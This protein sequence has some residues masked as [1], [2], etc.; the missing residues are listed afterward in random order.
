MKAKKL[1][2]MMTV[3]MFAFFFV[4][5]QAFAAGQEKETGAVKSQT[6]E[7]GTQKG[8]SGGAGMAAVCSRASEIIGRTVKNDKGEEL[9][10]VEDVVIS[11]N[12]QVLYLILA[13]GGVLGMGEN[14]IPIP[15]KMARMDQAEDAIIISNVDKQKLEKAP[16]FDKK[17]WVKS[18]GQAEMEQKI[19]GYYGQEPTGYPPQRMRGTEQE[20]MMEG[21]EQKK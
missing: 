7:R 11:Q 13:R 10:E 16:S 19:Y 17:D 6:Y 9:G 4:G 2:S 1:F 3:V 18:L 5:T 8:M 21:T 12:G 20:K 15:Y 14:L